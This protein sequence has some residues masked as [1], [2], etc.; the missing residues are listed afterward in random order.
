[1]KGILFVAGR[2]VTVCCLALV[3][4]FCPLAAGLGGEGTNRSGSNHLVGVRPF[5]LDYDS[6]SMALHALRSSLQ[7]GGR[8]MMYWELVGLSGAAFKFV[9][10]STAAFEPLRDVYPIDVLREASVVLGFPEAHWETAKPLDAV[11]DIVRNEIDRGRPV[12]APFLKVDAYHGFFIITGYDFDRTVFY[13]QGAFQSRSGEVTV[14]IPE[15]WDG[16]TVS[17]AGWATN[18]VFVLGEKSNESQDQ[19]IAA[20]RTIERG[21]EQMRG[22]KVVYGVHPGERRYMEY[23]GPHEATCG[24]PAYDLLSS[25]IENGR[26]VLHVG[27]EARLNF[28]LIWRIDSQ[29]GQLEHDRSN[30]ATFLDF[31]PRKLP[32]G[33]VPRLK[34]IVASFEETAED[35]SVLR[36]IFWDEGPDTLTAAESVAEYVNGSSSIIFHIPDRDGLPDELQSLGF[37]LF[38]TAWGWVLVDD[39]HEKR[40]LAKTALHSIVV[41]E[42]RSIGMLED[43]LGYIEQLL[44][45][46]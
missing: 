20:R 5:G 19:S 39:T 22:G 7:A 36:K 14:P 17:P 41:R 4:V 23:G 6:G 18:P 42:R 2:P 35:A 16:P 37:D 1:M 3:L 28:G 31:L 34:E 44:P 12:L 21:L 9:Y 10:D 24:L 11:K 27:G 13:L 46:E 32:P 33:P 15:A 45:D 8:S 40:M 43:I 29:V 26:F 30:G 38:R 25:D